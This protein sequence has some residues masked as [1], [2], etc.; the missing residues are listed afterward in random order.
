[1]EFFT[2]IA[3]NYIPKARIL[4]KS[5]KEHNNDAKF[6]LIINERCEEITL[7]NGEPFDRI[8]PV[9]DLNIPVENLDS[10][11]FQHDAYELCTAVKPFAFLEIMKRYNLEKLTF[12]DPDT[13]VF[14]DL[15]F[16]ENMLDEYSFLLTPHVIF[17]EVETRGIEVIEIS[18][19]THGTFNLGFL[20]VRKDDTVS[21]LLQW[22]GERLLHYCRRDRAALAGGLFVDQKWM[23]VSISLFENFKILRDESLNVAPWNI[24]TRQLT[25][26]SDGKFY[27]N[28][29]PL[30]FYHFSK[31][32]SGE[33]ERVMEIIAPYQAVKDL[34]KWYKIRLEE[35]DQEK[36]S[37]SR[38]SYSSFS[39]GELI[40][41]E[42]RLAYRL[43]K[44][45][46]YK[47]SDPFID[48]SAEDSFFKWSK[49]EHK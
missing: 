23:D 40:T 49:R 1:M 41:E 20:S 28:Q 8:I 7:D 4:A 19:L 27:V 10:W 26:D 30:S 13:V 35:E 18:A 42:Q 36:Y 2:S 6:T 45:L 17:P 33:H 9:K 37:Q 25:Q 14:S 32:D 38:W 46:H 29:Q 21:G 39:N 3:N 48:F 16:L 11:I 34:I 12:L 47:Y 15:T 43:N 24:R 44:D 22:W 5:V 31:I